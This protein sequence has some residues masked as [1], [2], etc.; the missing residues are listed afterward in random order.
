MRTWIVL[1]SL[2][3]F[4]VMAFAQQ[5]SP[6]Q[7]AANAAPAGGT[8]AMTVVGCVNSINGDFTLGTPQ[9][10]VYRLKGDH[11]ALLGYNGRKVAISGTVTSSEKA[12]TLQISTIKKLSDTCGY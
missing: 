12:R 2:L 11:D 3:L 5:P 8:R 7:G 1:P 6:S 4:S 10:E 9:G